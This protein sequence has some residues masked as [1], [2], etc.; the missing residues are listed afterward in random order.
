MESNYGLE[1]EEFCIRL[2][3]CDSY[4]LSI[5]TR[6]KERHYNVNFRGH[7]DGVRKGYAFYLKLS[8][9]EWRI[10]EELWIPETR[11]S[12]ENPAGTN[13]ELFLEPTKP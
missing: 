9:G 6:Q 11:P 8:D 5:T 3:K 12:R 13:L 2:F 7:D 1:F 10:V 4:K